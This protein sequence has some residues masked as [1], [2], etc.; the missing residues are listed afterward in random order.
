MIRSPKIARPQVI[1]A[2]GVLI[3]LIG[4]AF[5]GAA[6]MRKEKELTDEQKKKTTSE[7]NLVK[8]LIIATICGLLSACFSFA[9]SEN[10]G[11]LIGKRASELHTP[12]LWSGLP[13]LIVVM[14]GGLLTNAIWCASLLAKNRSFGEFSGKP[15]DPAGQVSPLASNYFFS[16]LAGLTWYFQF[17]FYTMG[18]SQ[19]GDSSKYSSWTL[20]MACI[21]IFSTLWGIVLKEWKGTSTRTHWLIG[22]G[23]LILVLSTV[24]VGI[25][26]YLCPARLLHS[27][28]NAEVGAYLVKGGSRNTMS[29]ARRP[30]A[31]VSGHHHLHPSYSGITTEF[32]EPFLPQA[33]LRYN[34][35]DSG[36]KRSLASQRTRL[37]VWGSQV[38]QILSLP[39]KKP[40]KTRG[41]ARVSPVFRR[42]LQLFQTTPNCFT[43]GEFGGGV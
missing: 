3:C 25:G 35:P 5:S 28:D 20:H 18:S 42:G 16:A 33:L 7:F 4:I 27:L 19:L 6:G 14:A 26:N 32:A 36:R 2:A 29:K 34:A 22:L 10:A 11:G 43:V 15:T 8:G 12:A 9:L 17:F 23:L 31:K 39:I 24:V 13:A 30:A 41:L 37:G 1:L 21:I 38:R 40:Y